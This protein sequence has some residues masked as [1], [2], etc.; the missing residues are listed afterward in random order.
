MEIEARTMAQTTTGGRLIGVTVLPEY[1]QVEG[2]D[3]VL[4][5]LVGAGANAVT[6]SPY[7]MEPADENSG[8]R[9]PPIDAGAGSVRLLDRPLWGRRELFVRT[10]PSFEPERSLYRGLRYQPAEPSALT[11]SDGRIVGEFIRAAQAR[12][13]KVY[14]QVQAAI[15]PGYRVQFGGPAEDDKPR[16]PDG[17]VPP[18]RVANNGSLA[19]PHVAAYT[20]ALLRDLCRAYPDVDGIRVD[21][22]EYPPYSL[23]DVFV[24]FSEHARAAA[25][26]LGWD[27]ERMRRE[28]GAVYEWLHGGLG[29]G[30]LRQWAERDGGRHV[31]VRGLARN[32]GVCEWLALKAQLVDELLGGLRK[33]LDEAAGRRMDL[34]PNAF[35][36][37]F[38]L[39]SGFDFALA[40]RHSAGISTKLYTMH[41]P[42]MARFYGDALAKANPALSERVLAR[43][44]AAWF[45]MFDDEGPERLADY[46]YPEPDEPHPAGIEAQLRKLA[47]A[48]AEAGNVPV[49]ALA[50]GYGPVDD[51]ERRFRA[52]LGGS[53][54]GVWVNRYGYL[55]DE[56][57][58]AMRRAVDQ[59]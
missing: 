12:H 45:D 58:G 44:L 22:P 50:H 56:K 23:D 51:F 19:S 28:V 40:A 15:P 29:D 6:T 16:L 34:V 53:R 1:I 14:L 5:K 38:T 13:F 36:V 32:T 59:V 26:R 25:A 55:S 57:L 20:N 18:R 41:W 31:L 35:A 43:A 24:D 10:A 9:E 42:M 7:V 39:A 2:I 37:P 21:W 46:Y 47:A 52:A 11:R 30:D 49:Y 17:R 33:T 3:G 8:S 54:H 48:Q 4:D 27:F